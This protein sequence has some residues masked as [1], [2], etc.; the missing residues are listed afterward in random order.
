M[1]DGND[2][3]GMHTQVSARRKA[4]GCNIRFRA[5]Y[6]SKNLARMFKID[7]PLG[8]QRQTSRCPVDEAHA[9][10]SLQPGDELC[11]RG[12]RQA[13]IV[14]CA[15]KAATLRHTLENGHLS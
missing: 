2:R 13:Y 11:H 12:W 3:E 14:G 15:R 6:R 1:M 9:E 4:C 10:A 7:F 8:G 5:L